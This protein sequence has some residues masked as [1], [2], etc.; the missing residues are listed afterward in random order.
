[1]VSETEKALV[2]AIRQ[3]H[4]KELKCIRN[5]AFRQANCYWLAKRKLIKKLGWFPA[6][7]RGSEDRPWLTKSEN[8]FLNALRKPKQKFSFRIPKT[9]FVIRCSICSWINGDYCLSDAYDSWLQHSNVAHEQN[10]EA[11]ALI[12]ETTKTGN[13]YM[14]HNSK[15][16][17]TVQKFIKYMEWL[18]IHETVLDKVRET[19]FAKLKGWIQ[20]RGKLK[21]GNKLRTVKGW[22][23]NSEPIRS[24]GIVKYEKYTDIEGKQRK[25]IIVSP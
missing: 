10:S 6:L 18:Q 21:I 25:L 5:R 19:N 13:F 7:F 15:G 24:F 20:I 3:H 23:R 17:R 11:E 22:T 16:K 2:K 9:L 1:M 12:L 4:L 8:S 14:I